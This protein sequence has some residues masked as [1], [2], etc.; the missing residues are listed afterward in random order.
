MGNSVEKV[1]ADFGLPLIRV[2][3]GPFIC[4]VFAPVARSKQRFG[5]WKTVS[6]RTWRVF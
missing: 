3:A 6:G 4:R 1:G 2:P 5:A